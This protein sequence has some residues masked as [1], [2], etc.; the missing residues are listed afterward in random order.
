[1]VSMLCQVRSNRDTFELPVTAA[2]STVHRA[3]NK[4]VLEVMDEVWTRLG[5]GIANLPQR[6]ARHSRELL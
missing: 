5:G 6:E 3:I 2:H 1:M 4:K